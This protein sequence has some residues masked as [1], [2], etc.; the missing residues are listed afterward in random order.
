MKPSIQTYLIL[1]LTP[2]F[3]HA[4]DMMTPAYY[5]GS[6]KKE[7]DTFLAICQNIQLQHP[8]QNKA[9]DLISKHLYE[10][11][12][13]GPHLHFEIRYYRPTDNGTE[14]FYGFRQSAPGAGD[15]PNGRWDPDHG[16]GFGPPASHGLEHL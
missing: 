3:L 15:W 14:E 4:A 16:Y 7:A 6:L 10:G 9:G 8:L 2:Y 11:T 5:D 1:T 13:G 12:R